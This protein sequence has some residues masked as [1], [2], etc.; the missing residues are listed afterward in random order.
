[1][2]ITPATVSFW[3]LSTQ[4]ALAYL[5]PGAGSIVLQGIIAAL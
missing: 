1:M 4:H 5:D 2:W 3:L